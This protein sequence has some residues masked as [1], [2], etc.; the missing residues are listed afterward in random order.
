MRVAVHDIGTN[1]TRLLVAD[2]AAPG[3]LTELER[4]SEVTR[5]GVG[6]ERT[7]RLSDEGMAR[8]FAALDD[9]RERIEAL[10][11]ADR[12]IAVLTSATRDAA[13]GPQFVARVREEDGL[14]ARAIPGEE[15]ARLSFRGATTGR[16]AGEDPIA[17]LDIGGGSTEFIVG[18]HGAMRFHVSTQAGVVRQSERHVHHDPPLPE[19]LDALAADV[20]EVFAGAVPAEVR[21][22]AQAMIAVAGTATSMAAIDQ[23]LE[24]FDAAR[25]HGHRVGLARAEEI[26]DR[27]AAMT[28][29]ERRGVRG[30]HPERAP[31]IV[32]GS[33]LLIEAMRAFGLDEV[34]VSEHDILH[35]VALAAAGGEL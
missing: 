6:V 7:G 34:E 12:R 10:G 31:T 4:R 28:D 25:V 19:E 20:R 16:E 30:L 3:V 33:L 14:E 27:L 26:R 2:V 24:P 15:E 17:V 29:A 11:G 22:Q 18:T 32:A 1:S 8:V 35:G 23:E 5:L 21:A 9:Y 13:N